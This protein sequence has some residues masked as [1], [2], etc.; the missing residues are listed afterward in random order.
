MQSFIVLR[1]KIIIF[2]IGISR[3]HR[4][5][6]SQDHYNRCISYNVLHTH[7]GTQTL[8]VSVSVMLTGSHTHFH[9]RG[10]QAIDLKNKWNIIGP[11]H[12]PSLTHLCPSHCLHHTLRLFNGKLSFS[13]YCCSQTPSPSSIESYLHPFFLSVSNN[14][15]FPFLFKVRCVISVPQRHQMDMWK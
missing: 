11:S 3:S 7:T 8:P 12:T 13:T 4:I 9:P 10:I 2:K 6:I 14:A 5:V 1:K 15:L